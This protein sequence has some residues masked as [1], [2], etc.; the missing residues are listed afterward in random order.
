ML[1]RSSLGSFSLTSEEYRAAGSESLVQRSSDIGHVP[2]KCVLAS[3]VLES[4][5]PDKLMDR[6]HFCRGEIQDTSRVQ[7]GAEEN[8]TQL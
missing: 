5:L 1:Q 4:S 8:H 2:T 3:H 7:E 6:T